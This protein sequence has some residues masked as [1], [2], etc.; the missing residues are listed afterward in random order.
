MQR[1]RE[2]KLYYLGV[3]VIMLTKDCSKQNLAMLFSGNARL[4]YARLNYT[5]I[6]PGRESDHVDKG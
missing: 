3:I 2:T 4:N 5:Y 6:L 1:K